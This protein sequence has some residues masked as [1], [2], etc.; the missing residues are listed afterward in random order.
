MLSALDTA[1]LTHRLLW[2]PYTMDARA[3]TRTH[4]RAHARIQVTFLCLGLHA[5]VWPKD[6]IQSTRY[7]VQDKTHVRTLGAVVV[8]RV[9]LTDGDIL[10]VDM[11]DEKRVK[12][13]LVRGLR[14]SVGCR[15]HPLDP[16]PAVVSVRVPRNLLRTKCTSKE[17]TRCVCVSARDG[18]S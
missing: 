6:N 5:A 7:A 2:V 8:A 9:A 12:Q 17:S 4:A 11:I 1:P 10:F 14:N 16:S 3:R 13:L 18:C 15:A